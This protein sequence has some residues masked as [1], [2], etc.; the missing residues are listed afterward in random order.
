[1][2]LNMLFPAL[3]LVFAT[4]FGQKPA[5]VEI[6]KP[7][8]SGENKGLEM[9]IPNTTVE[10]VERALSERVKFYKGKFNK[11]SGG[12]LEYASYSCKI[13]TLGTS[14]TDIYSYLFQEDQSVRM[15]NFYYFE[16][17][18]VSAANS[19]KFDAASKFAIEVYNKIIFDQMQVKLDVEE[20]ALKGF[21]KEQKNLYNEQDNLDNDIRKYNE[22]I[23]KSEG[24][25]KENESKK[26]NNEKL[27]LAQKDKII[28]KET[29]L[30]QYNKLS[31]E[32]EIKNLEKDVK[33]LEKI[34]DKLKDELKSKQKEPEKYKELLATYDKQVNDN[35]YKLIDKNRTITEKKNFFK[36]NVLERED[37]LKDLIKERD[38]I[39]NAIKNNDKEIAENK[40]NIEIQKGKISLAES[41]LATNKTAQI[42]AKANVLKQQGVV[43]NLKRQQDPYR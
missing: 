17:S 11:P 32:T 13:P 16:G 36:L 25:I 15:T 22:S 34:N 6:K 43:D 26:L 41:N 33:D 5:I 37:Q 7:M 23:S 3:L 8:S 10:E 24:D 39:I 18:F 30:K 29:E 2:K 35:N 12:S 20:K 31:M 28:T 19:G 38:K 27:L 1:M 40:K 14:M 4:S 42:N 9:V 21:I